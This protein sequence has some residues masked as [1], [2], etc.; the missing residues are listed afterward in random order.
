MEK[1]IETQEKEKT[2][3]F[4]QLPQ[5]T[6]ELRNEVRELRQLLMVKLSA[7]TPAEPK[8]WMNISELC[9]YLPD[10]PSKQTIY[11]KVCYH[12]IPFHKSAKK[13][14][15]LKS[16]IDAW[17]ANSGHETVDEIREKAHECYGN[18]KGGAR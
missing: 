9:A 11:T 18:R 6:L 15:F 8:E 12:Q 5:V 7:P 3:T 1:N 4:D 17:L 10:H 13:L 16:E 2:I 14:S